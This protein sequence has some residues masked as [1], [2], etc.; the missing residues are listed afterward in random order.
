[1]VTCEKVLP[2]Q[3]VLLWIFP[4]IRNLFERYAELNLLLVGT[5]QT[6]LNMELQ[7]DDRTVC[8]SHKIEILI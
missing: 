8:F 7:Q 4:E 2:S 3:K 5:G 6:P 1:M